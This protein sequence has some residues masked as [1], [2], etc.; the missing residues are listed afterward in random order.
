M[1][2]ASVNALAVVTRMIISSAALSSIGD[3][4]LSSP[5]VSTESA[6]SNIASKHAMEARDKAMSEVCC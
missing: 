4:S 5:E 3:S 6:R 1:D 2:D